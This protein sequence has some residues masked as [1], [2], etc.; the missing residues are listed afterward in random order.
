MLSQTEFWTGVIAFCFPA[1]LY[2]LRDVAE[3][4]AREDQLQ[5]AWQ[6]GDKERRTTQT[7]VWFPHEIGLIIAC[8]VD[9]A[10]IRAL[11]S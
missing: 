9:I 2:L 11:L 8:L 4:F 7:E 1:L 5:K 3:E 6:W 10:V